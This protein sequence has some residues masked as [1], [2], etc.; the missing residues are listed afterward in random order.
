MKN[1]DHM[2]ISPLF[3]VVAICV[4]FSVSGSAS[5]VEEDNLPAAVNRV[6]RETGGRVLSAERR[7]QSGREINRIKVYTPEGRMRVMWDDPRGTPPR[8]PRDTAVKQEPRPAAQGDTP[9]QPP[10]RERR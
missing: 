1:L 2:S 7:Q 8:A 10:R 6:E 3:V 4:G 5:A 9:T